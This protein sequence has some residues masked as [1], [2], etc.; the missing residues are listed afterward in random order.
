[1]RSPRKKTA[2]LLCA[3]AACA[4]C[5]AAARLL[6]HSGAQS[7]G[8]ASTAEKTYTAADFGIRTVHSSADFNRNG[9]D[10]Y[11]D[12][13]R[14]ARAD[15]ENRP[16]YDNSYYTGGYP[17]ENAGACTDVV[18]R[19]F[20][21]AGYSLKDMVDRDIAEHP[22]SYPAAGAKPDPNIDFR[23]VPNLKIYFERHAVPLTTDPKQIAAWQPGDIV[24]FGTHHIGVLSDRRDRAGIP[25]LIHNAGQPN[26]EED[27]LTHWGPL[28]GHFRFDAARLP[29]TDLIPFRS[30]TA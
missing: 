8:G 23:R 6:P 17:P 25:Y 26:R 24:T 12:F 5:F 13:L 2:L 29:N 4:V 15:A 21:A 14:G 18:W 1:M 16:A 19:A 9:A 28:S 10:D 11:S 3:A 22:G 20:R 7:P 27:A 30:Q